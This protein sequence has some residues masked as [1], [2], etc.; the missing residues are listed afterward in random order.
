[1]IKYILIFFL[2]FP[3]LAFSKKTVEKKGYFSCYGNFN[4]TGTWVNDSEKFFTDYQIWLKEDKK[5]FG[6]LWIDQTSHPVARPKFWES[7]RVGKYVYTLTNQSAYAYLKDNSYPI[8]DGKVTRYNESINFVT[9]NMTARMTY[10]H[11]GDDPVSVSIV[12]RCGKI[13]WVNKVYVDGIETNEISKSENSPIKNF[14]GKL[15]GK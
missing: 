7:S 3:Q 6:A 11:D 2:F 5:T 8:Q 12:A 14:L 15:L 1:M 9:G 13:K 4:R 10:I